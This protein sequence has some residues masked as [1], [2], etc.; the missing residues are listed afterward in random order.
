LKTDILNC[1]NILQHYCFYC[2]QVTSNKLGAHKTSGL[3]HTFKV[4]SFM[5]TAH[6]VK[7]LFFF[8]FKKKKSRTRDLLGAA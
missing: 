5:Y 6:T 7:L 2:I 4:N 1:Y 8:F 3:I